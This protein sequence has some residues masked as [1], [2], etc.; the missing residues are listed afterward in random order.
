M[1][2]Y[3]TTA[4]A[5][6]SL[7]RREAG[8]IAR[9]HS[10]AASDDLL[11]TVNTVWRVFKLP[12][13]AKIV[14]G[15]AYMWVTATEADSPAG[16]LDLELYDTVGT[17]AYKLIDGLALAAATAA[18]GG[19]TSTLGLGTGLGAHNVVT[20]DDQWVI[21]VLVQTAGDSTMVTTGVIGVSVLYTV[22]LEPGQ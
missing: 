14:P 2:T 13:G 19:Q 21:R 7:E 4:F 18:A 11:E 20:D 5:L 6:P 17:T 8:V 12:K 3:D 1:A 22:D 15:T 10:F 9:V 16:L